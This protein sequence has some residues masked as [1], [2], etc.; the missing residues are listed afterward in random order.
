MDKEYAAF[1]VLAGAILGWVL[2][3]GL[4]YYLV[5]NG[6]CPVGIECIPK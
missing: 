5:T 4:S 1:L 3:W 2:A 6:H